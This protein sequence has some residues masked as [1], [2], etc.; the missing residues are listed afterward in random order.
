MPRYTQGLM[1]IGATICL[2]RNPSCLLCP[3]RDS[4]LACAQGTQED[5]PIKTRKLKRSSQSLWLLRARTRDGATWLEKRP[6]TGIWAG[7]YCLPVYES[8]DAL[9]A[10]LPQDVSAKLQDG[11]PFLHVL[12]HKDLHLHP[13]AAHVPKSA[14]REPA[15]AW[16][17]SSDWP[18]LG[19]PAPIRRLLEAG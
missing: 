5:Y 9:Q 3:L 11:D 1:D 8:R 14:M 19:L 12:T 10:A 17:A 7:L 6:A 15:G 2:A 13:V 18:K 4:C 16:F